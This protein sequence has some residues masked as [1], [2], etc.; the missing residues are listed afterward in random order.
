M[1]GPQNDFLLFNAKKGPPNQIWSNLGHKLGFIP[2]GPQEFILG[3]KMGSKWQKSGNLS[4]PA[5]K[6]GQY[7]P[8]HQVWSKSDKNCQNPPK[9]C[10][11]ILDRGAPLKLEFFD[12]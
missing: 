2:F 5:L 8:S 3:A 6:Y 10:P 1:F 4:Y 9:S 11:R 12:S 7:P